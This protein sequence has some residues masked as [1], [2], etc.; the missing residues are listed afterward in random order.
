ML[1]IQLGYCLANLPVS[2]AII[3][4]FWDVS[5]LTVPRW[6]GDLAFNWPVCPNQGIQLQETLITSGIKFP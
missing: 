4:V 3:G 1:R 2:Q 5:E 6:V